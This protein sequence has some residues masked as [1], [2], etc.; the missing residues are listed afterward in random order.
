MQWTRRANSNNSNNTQQEYSAGKWAW[1]WHEHRKYPGG[2]VCVV[3]NSVEHNTGQC[4]PQLE[5][6]VKAINGTIDSRNATLQLWPNY[7]RRMTLYPKAMD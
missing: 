1:T 2:R 5:G 7:K 3:F 4:I 6:A